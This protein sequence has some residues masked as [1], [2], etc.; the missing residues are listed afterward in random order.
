MEV[1][2][3]FKLWNNLQH[4][5]ILVPVSDNKAWLKGL[6]PA[7]DIIDNPTNY[8]WIYNSLENWIK[9]LYIEE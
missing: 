8:C 3:P 1:K 6:K 9:H 5:D 4:I 7:M 2:S